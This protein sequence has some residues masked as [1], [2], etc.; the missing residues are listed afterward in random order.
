MFTRAD[1]REARAAAVR[2]R[3]LAPH[4]VRGRHHRPRPDP[5]ALRAAREARDQGLR[6]VLRLEARRGRRPLPGRDRLGSPAR[7]AQGDRRHVGRARDRRD[8]PDLPHH[9]ERLRVHGRRHL[10][11][12]PARAAAQGHGVHAVPPDDALP[13]RDPDDRGLPRRGRLPDQQ[14]RRAVHGALRAERAR[15]RLARR[16]LALRADRDRRGPRHQRQRHARHAPPRRRRRSSTACRARASSRSPTPASTRSTSRCRSGR[17]PTTTWAA[18]RPT[19]TACTELPGLYAAGEVGVRVRARRQPPRRQLADGD[20]HLRPA[21]R[22]RGRRGVADRPG[23]GGGSRVG[24][25]R[26][27][28]GARRRCSTGTDGERPWKIRDELG[29][30]MLDNFGV[31]R[32]EDADAGAGRDHRRAPRALREGGRR[33]QGRRLQQRPDP[34]ARARRLPRAR[35]LHA[36]GGL[37]RKE[38]R[39]AHA[40]PQDFPDRDDESFLKHSESAGSTAI[41]R[42]AGARSRSRSG[43]PS[44]GATDAGRLEDLAL[45]PRAG[46]AS[47]GVRGRRARGGDAARRARSREGPATTARSPTA[48]AAG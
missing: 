13:D 33:G 2:R 19:R 4:G 3:R 47:C 31:F 44:R 30:S 9:D 36:R 42:T 48:R 8:R 21:R 29:A 17:A 46:S 34:G 15:A 1:G 26:C 39:G 5:G 28:G 37:E 10:D 7:R 25:R 24:A 27:P 14:G 11:G 6:G 18:S 23:A 16:R 35:R 40:R 43:N 22:A 20:D 32:R 38:S 45:D 41:R 12:A